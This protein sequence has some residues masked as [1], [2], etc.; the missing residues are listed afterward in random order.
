MKKRKILAVTWE[1]SA[2]DGG[3]WHRPEDDK[4]GTILA[5]SVGYLYERNK[6]HIVLIPHK[7][8]TGQAL[9]TLAIPTSAVRKIKRLR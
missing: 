3:G 5:Y 2:S 9:G 8:N 7:T 1:D 4:P 6:Q